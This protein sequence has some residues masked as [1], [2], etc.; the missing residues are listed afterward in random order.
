MKEGI[1]LTGLIAL[2][3]LVPF[4]VSGNGEE[5]NDEAKAQGPIVKAVVESCGGWRLNRLPDVKQFIYDDVPLF[6]NVEFVRKPGAPPL[7]HF[8]NSNDERVET[9]DLEKMSRQDCNQELIRRGFYRKKTL[10]EQVPPEFQHGPYRSSDE[11]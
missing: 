5:P 2:L 10:H 7:L 4:S 3:V 9:V 11:L 1:L 6:H 8:L